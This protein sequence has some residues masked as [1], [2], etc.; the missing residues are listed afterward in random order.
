MTFQLGEATRVAH[1]TGIP[2]VAEFRQSDVAAGG[3]GAPLVPWTDWVLF[4]H[5]AMARAVQNIGGVAN[6]TWIPAGA[7]ADEVRGFDT[8]PGNMVIDTLVTRI[9]NGR[10]M[11]DR[12]GRRAARGRVLNEILTEWLRH[13][14]LRRRPPK[15]T[16]REEFGRPFVDAWLP[17]L[18]AASSRPEDWIAT[19]TAFTARSIAYSV[20]GLMTTSG[21]AELGRQGRSGKVSEAAILSRRSRA[22]RAG[23]GARGSWRGGKQGG[24]SKGR[25]A[26]V[27]LI[28]CGGGAHNP[29]LVRMIAAELR[30]LAVARIDDYNIPAQAKEGLSFAM[31]AAAYVDRTPANLPQITGASQSVLL[32]RVILP[33]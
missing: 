29:V 18:R 7:A 14:F 1:R 8:G 32:G 24:S 25:L 6:I 31:L 17:R 16:G 19:A 13:P 33:A 9:S 28:L 5:P 20:R 22:Q 26:P 10:Q 15:T 2:V 23:E 3:Q 11:Y 12:D 27:E 4:R 30:D 21:H